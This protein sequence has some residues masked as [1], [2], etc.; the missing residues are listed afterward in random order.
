MFETGGHNSFDLASFNQLDTNH[1]RKTFLDVASHALVN[2]AN[3][4]DR[5]SL[6][7]VTII[8]VNVTV[9]IKDKV[10]TD[11]DIEVDR[12]IVIDFDTAIDNGMSI[13]TNS[14][15][16]SLF[17]CISC[18]GSE[19]N[20]PSLTLLLPWCAWALRQRLLLLIRIITGMA[21]ESLL[22]I[23]TMDVKGAAGAHLLIDGD[24]ENLDEIAMRSDGKATNSSE[25]ATGNLDCRLIVEPVVV[26][27]EVRAC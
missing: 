23:L 19:I 18:I 9:I 24:A 10:D 11:I 14:S 7:L 4:L 6:L 27:L 5:L 22:D 21:V 20:L 26:R 16:S 17:G 25:L 2:S 13:G 8:T 1:N 12:G 15:S 3:D